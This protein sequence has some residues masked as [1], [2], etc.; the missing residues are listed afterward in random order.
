MAKSAHPPERIPYLLRLATRLKYD[1]EDK[2]V[3]NRRSLN[4][5]ICVRLE[6]SLREETAPRQHL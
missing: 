5:E 4:Q 6:R 2:A 1:L 3:Q